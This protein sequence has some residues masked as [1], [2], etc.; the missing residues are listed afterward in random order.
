MGGVGR[1]LWRHDLAQLTLTSLRPSP[2][3]NQARGVP[4]RSQRPAVLTRTY[5]SKDA[6]ARVCPIIPTR[7]LPKAVVLPLSGTAW[8]EGVKKKA[9]S[10]RERWCVRVRVFTIKYRN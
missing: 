10:T 3:T 1:D 2:C 5:T 7:D 8:E 6:H 9:L 4:Q